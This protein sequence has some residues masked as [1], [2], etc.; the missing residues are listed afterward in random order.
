MFV[1][2]VFKIVMYLKGLVIVNYWLNDN[3]CKFIIE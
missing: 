1:F 3:S 2:F